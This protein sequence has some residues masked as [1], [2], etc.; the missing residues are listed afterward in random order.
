MRDVSTPITAAEQAEVAY[1]E[2]RRSL[3]KFAEAE[4]ELLDSE[5]RLSPTQETIVMSR[6]TLWRE[7]AVMFAAI[8]QAERERVRELALT[9]AKV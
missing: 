4:S 5:R 1:G 6:L 7:R 8:Y 9:R 3:V 2:L